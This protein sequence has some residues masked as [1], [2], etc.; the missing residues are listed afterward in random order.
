MYYTIEQGYIHKTR[1]VF[2]HSYV[3]KCIRKSTYMCFVT[4]KTKPMHFVSKHTDAMN[5][6]LTNCIVP[7]SEYKLNLMSQV[8]L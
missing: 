7:I 3:Y 8:N 4:V 2:F 6:E 5:K 1:L